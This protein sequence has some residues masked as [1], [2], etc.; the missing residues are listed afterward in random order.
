V[1][2]TALPTPSLYAAQ[3]SVSIDG[4]DQAALAVRVLSATVEEDAGGMRRCEVRFGNWGDT[5]QGIGFVHSDRRLL[6]FG[7]LIDIDIGAGE[8]RGRVFNGLVTGIEEH[9]PAGRVPEIVVLAED[10][11]Q[12]LRMTR[13]TRT[14]ESVTAADV[15]RRVAG[16]HGLRSEIDI[17]APHHPVLVQLNQSDL[18]FLR[19]RA[20][21][22]DAELWLADDVLHVQARGRRDAGPVS[23]SYGSDLHEFSVLADLSHQSTAVSVTG[24]DVAAKRALA[25]EVTAS[26]ITAELDGGASGPDILERAFGA[27]VEH[28]VQT[29]PLG[30]EEARAHAEAR[31]RACARRFVTGAGVAEGD[32][33]ITVGTHVELRGLSPAFRGTYYVTEVLHRY[34]GTSGFLTDFRA[35]RAGLGGPP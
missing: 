7:R 12:E 6:D 17:D 31:F 10:R 14:F 13:R 23:L 1:S 11:L 9:Y 28:V 5:G 29:V 19:G 25:Q 27:R 22:V 24:W 18:A 16:E 2:L 4:S 32:A 33:R 20:R 8:R 26:T 3:P 35:E 34:D 21:A 15:F 30:S